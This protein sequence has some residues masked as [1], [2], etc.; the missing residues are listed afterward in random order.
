MLILYP[1]LSTNSR[2]ALF[3]TRRGWNHR[4]T[5]KPRSRLLARLSQ[6]SGLSKEAVIEQLNKEREILL[7]LNGI[8]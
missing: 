6:E 1:K 3:K 8:R 2:R 7:K 4:Y 5:Y